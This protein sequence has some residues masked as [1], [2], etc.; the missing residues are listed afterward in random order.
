MEYNNSVRITRLKVIPRMDK[1][2][3][4]ILSQ[5]HDRIGSIENVQIRCDDRE[6]VVDTVCYI[7]LVDKR[8]HP[9]L[10]Y[11]L[12][13]YI[14]HD[15]T[16]VVTP[17]SYTVKTYRSEYKLNPE[18][19]ESCDQYSAHLQRYEQDIMS[20][21]ITTKIQFIYEEQTRMAHSIEAR[22][23]E[24][25]RQRLEWY[26]KASTT[27]SDNTTP[28]VNENVIENSTI[29]ETSETRVNDEV[30][31]NAI[32]ANNAKSTM[33]RDEDVEAYDLGDDVNNYGDDSDDDSIV[34]VI[35]RT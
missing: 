25:K 10:I 31:V 16:I 18:P 26:A 11:F 5:L 6:D 29:P 22:Q 12:H 8:L 13:N 32:N 19:C 4:N 23:L 35:P 3:D 1:H 7:Q 27:V 30:Q 33:Q 21:A 9:K 2:L 14:F 20:R 24:R 34:T 15:R 17:S 28:A